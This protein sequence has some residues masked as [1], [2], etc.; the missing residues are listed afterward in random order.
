MFNKANTAAQAPLISQKVLLKKLLGK[1]KPI[2]QNIKN[3]SP[4]KKNIV[5]SFRLILQK[6]ALNNKAALIMIM[7]C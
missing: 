4:K 1:T 5:F 3:N 2:I 6:K 7:H